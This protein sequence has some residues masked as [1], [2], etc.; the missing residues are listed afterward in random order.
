MITNKRNQGHD[1]LGQLFEGVLQKESQEHRK[2]GRKTAVGPTE[3][4]LVACP[5]QCMSHNSIKNN[6]FPNF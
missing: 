1:P 3:R 2:W 4:S 6:L 5:L